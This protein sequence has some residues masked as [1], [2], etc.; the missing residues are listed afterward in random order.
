MR[1]LHNTF[2]KYIFQLNS[3]YNFPTWAREEREKM[4]PRIPEILQ[5]N[6]RYT[7]IPG[8]N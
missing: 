4:E 1:K 3:E 2:E 7:Y 8:L 5:S 6:K